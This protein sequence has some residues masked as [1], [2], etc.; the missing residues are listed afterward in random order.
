MVRVFL[1]LPHQGAQGVGPTSEKIPSPK[2]GSQPAICP[3]FPPRAAPWVTYE[4][5]DTH[6]PVLHSL[7]PTGCIT[8]TLVDVKLGEGVC[9]QLSRTAGSIA[10]TKRARCSNENG[11]LGTRA[12]AGPLQCLPEQGPRGSLGAHPSLLFFFF[13]LTS[14]SSNSW[15]LQPYGGDL[16]TAAA[17]GMWHFDVSN[18]ILTRIDT[19]WR[20]SVHLPAGASRGA[21]GPCPPPGLPLPRSALASLPVFLPL[22][23][24][25]PGFTLCPRVSLCLSLSLGKKQ[26][27]RLS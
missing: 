26:T 27:F 19:E 7:V 21:S 25:F 10:V 18:L 5:N 11:D 23:P 12:G 14:I 3:P 4:E 6:S 13:F 9:A 15:L 17:P 1:W 24:P 8:S 2:W 22:L 16:P 20:M